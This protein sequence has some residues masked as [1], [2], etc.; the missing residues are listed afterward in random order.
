MNQYIIKAQNFKR[1]FENLLTGKWAYRL[2]E[3]HGFSQEDI[4]A[5]EMRYNI[6]LPQSYRVFL[7]EFGNTPKSF[8]LDLDMGDEHPLE[9]TKFFYD[10]MTIPEG[11]YIP[12]TNVPLNMFAFATYLYE[13]FYFFFQDDTS[14]DPVIYLASIFQ[15]GGQPF[16]FKKIGESVWDFLEE[17]IAKYEDGK[18]EGRYFV[19]N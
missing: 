5:I 16:K 10:V 19:D 2:Q 17:G 9:M 8:L 1:R 7:S 4:K 12:P 14:D 18:K 6:S 15:G 3:I 13:H 11:E